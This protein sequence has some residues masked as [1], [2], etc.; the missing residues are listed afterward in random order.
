MTHHLDD[1]EMAKALAGE[2]LDPPLTE[3][4][5]SCVSCRR[6][7]ERLSGLVADRRQQQ[8]A[9]AP[10]WDRQRDGIMARLPSSQSAQRRRP[11]W[12]RPLMAAAAALVVAAG[13]RIAWMPSAPVEVP[14]QSDLEVEEILAE[15]DEVLADDSLPGFESIDPGFDVAETVFENGAS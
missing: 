14:L 3:H 4:L 10:D 5:E 6:E 8:E 12:L 9:Q 15:V 13:L 2:A 7:V 11:V 1:R